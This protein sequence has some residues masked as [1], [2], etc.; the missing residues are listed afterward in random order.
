VI[1]RKDARAPSRNCLVPPGI[2]PS[3][4]EEII[5]FCRLAWAEARLQKRVKLRLCGLA[6]LRE[7]Q[8]CSCQSPNLSRFDRALRGVEK[9]QARMKPVLKTGKPLLN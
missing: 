1:S 7:I 6:A 9:S 2:A 3:E 8:S 4:S 5:N